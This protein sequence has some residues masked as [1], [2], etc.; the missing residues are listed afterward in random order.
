MF[1]EESQL[2]GYQISR[3]GIHGDVVQAHKFITSGRNGQYMACINPHS[4]VVASKDAL[5][6]LALKETD[7]LLPDGAGIVMAARFLNLPIQKRVAGFEFF[8]GL[9]A[10]LDQTCSTRYFFLGSTEYVLNQITQRLN[11]EFPGIIV[12]G[13]LSP[14]FKPEFT[15]EENAAMVATINTARPDVLWIGMTAPKQEKWIYANRNKLE[16]PFIG[17]IGAVFD[18]Y[19]GTKNRSSQFW[20]NLGL[21]WLPRLIKEPRRLW[22]RNLKSTPIFLSWVLR[23]KIKQ[24]LIR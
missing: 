22:E 21:E 18:F 24:L 9:S 10:S 7:L 19:A 17:A 13:T 2:F 5:F 23:E 3:R 8:H 11:K 20:I 4:L 12:C 14:P 6:R 16:V 15:D 1:Q